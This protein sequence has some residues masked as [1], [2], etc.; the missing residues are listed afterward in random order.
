MEQHVDTAIGRQPVA[1]AHARAQEALDTIHPVRRERVGLHGAPSHAVAVGE[2][3][4]RRLD[5]R[6]RIAVRDGERRIRKRREQRRDLL[7]VLRRL[8]HPAARAAQERQHLQHLAEVRIVL[9]LIEGEVEISP[10]RHACKP[11]ERVGGEVEVLELDLLLDRGRV[12]VMHGTQQ[13]HHRDLRLVVAP[14]PREAGVDT[15]AAGAVAG[16]WARFEALPVREGAQTGVGRDEVDEMGR[17][18]SREADHDDRRVELHGEDLGIPAD[19]VLHEKARGEE[20]HDPL[21]DGEPT[22]RVQARVGL[23]R[24]RH[25][26][27]PSPELGVPEVVASGPLACRCEQRVDVEADVERRD[28]VEGGAVGGVEARGGQIVDPNHVA[29]GASRR[30]PVRRP[31]HLALEPSR[32]PEVH[33]AMLEQELLVAR[34]YV[35]SAT[36]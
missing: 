4:D 23:D 21:V 6:Y 2:H 7:E 36:R 1:V 29:H 20:A 26:L 34:R 18:G 30:E 31:P 9:A 35:S 19:P 15:V 5:H 12:L 17:P 10:R 3:R 27:E 22:E 28:V 8:Q 16:A 25:R 11:F 24:G 32:E 14:V 33:A 13:R